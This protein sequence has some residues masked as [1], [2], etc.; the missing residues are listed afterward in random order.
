LDVDLVVEDDHVAWAQGVFIECNRRLN[1]RVQL[2]S[3]ARRNE[4]RDHLRQ[5]PGRHDVEVQPS[6][7]GLR[8]Q[9]KAHQTLEQD[10][11]VLVGEAVCG[12]L[13]ARL[14]RRKSPQ[15]AV[16]HEPE[17]QHPRGELV[18][19]PAGNDLAFA[20]ELATQNVQ[21]PVCARS[22]QDHVV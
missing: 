2:V 6:A 3:H 13:A 14:A 10:P 18:S 9:A 21:R 12:D 4:R 17:R 11:P 22:H 15:V 1:L 5:P 20:I 16:V 7:G 19:D 8:A